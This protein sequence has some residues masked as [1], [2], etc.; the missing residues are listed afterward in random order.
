MIDASNSKRLNTN[1]VAVYKDAY[2]RQAFT[3][4]LQAICAG[5]PAELG[6][7]AYQQHPVWR[8]NHWRLAYGLLH[9][10]MGDI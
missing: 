9:F 10:C 8:A 3:D 1:A 5:L 6:I 2:C 4:S 7:H